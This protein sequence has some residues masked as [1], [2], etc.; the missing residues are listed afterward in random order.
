MS[1]G[2]WWPLPVVH[3]R[4]CIHQKLPQGLSLQ[5]LCKQSGECCLNTAEEE[6]L[7]A[8]I[9]FQRKPGELSIPFN[10]NEGAVGSSSI[11]IKLYVCV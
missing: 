9:Y 5:F 1:G 10:S 11:S 8:G 7:L 3:A 4:W 2:V 6:N